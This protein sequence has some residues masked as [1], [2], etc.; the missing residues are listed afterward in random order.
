MNWIEL[1]KYITMK[2]MK[3]NK[4]KLGRKGRVMLSLVIAIGIYFIVW[5]IIG[6]II[7]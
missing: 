3:A 1:K 5:A 4:S 6:L 7:M 2:T